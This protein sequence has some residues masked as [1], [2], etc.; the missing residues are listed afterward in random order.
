MPADHPD[1]ATL[2]QILQQVAEG[3]KERQDAESGVWYQ[4]LQYDNTYV[5]ECG[6]ANYLEA[7]A[8]SMFTYAYLK[9]LRLGLLDESYRPMAE[10]AYQG[11]LTTFVTENADKSLN[12]NHS[13]RS[14]GLGPASSPSRDGSA[15]YYLCGGDV[16][17]VSNE[18]KSLGPFIMASLEYELEKATV[19]GQSAVRS[20]AGLTILQSA[21][22]I[23]LR[24]AGADAIDAHLTQLNGGKTVASAHQVGT[25][26]FPT[27]RL[28]AGAYL[29]YG[30]VDGRRYARKV[31]VVK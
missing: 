20:D 30:T 19:S 16:T 13:C 11:L 27:A 24:T 22:S 9:A 7:S 5:G 14:A 10:R 29:L 26:S 23:T 8:S 3:L 2:T 25:V 17:E 12:L 4:L 18:G 31:F 6:K 1:Y 28:A 15:S 21:D